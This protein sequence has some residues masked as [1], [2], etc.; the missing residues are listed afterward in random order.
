MRAP[1][2]LLLLG[3]LLAAPAWAAPTLEDAVERLQAGDLRG[4]A[5]LLEG[6]L[7]REPRNAQALF[8]LATARLR[9][10]DVAGGLEALRASVA[11]DPTNLRLRLILGRTY[12]RLRRVEEALAVYREVSRRG[13]EGPEGREARRRARLLEAKVLGE[14]GRLGEALERFEALA[15]EL[16]EDPEVLQGLGL[17]QLLLGRPEQARETF[18]RVASLQ[19]DNASVLRYLG[20]IAY[21]AGDLEEAERRYREVLRLAPPRAPVAQAARLRLAILRGLRA[22]DGG[23]YRA[24]AEAFQEALRLSPRDPVARLNLAAAYRG[25]ERYERAEALLLGLLQDDPDNLDARLRLGALYL[26]TQRSAEAARTLEALLDRAPDSPQAEQAR[27]LLEQ[28]YATPEGAGLRRQR[29]LGRIAALE[30]RLQESPEDAAAWAELARLRAEQGELEA[31]EE[32]YRRALALRPRQGRLLEEAAS[33]AE[34]RGAYA[35]AAERFARALALAETEAEQRRLRNRLRLAQAERLYSAGRLEAA[36]AWLREVLGEEPDNLFAHYLQGLIA[37]R[38]GRP[39]EAVEAY[40]QVLRLFPGHLGAHLNLAA[41][42]EQLGHLEEAMAQYRAVLR[43][44]SP[45]LAAQAAAR[46][47]ELR[48]RVRGFTYGLSFSLGYDDN[49]NL[50]RRNPVGQARS[51]LDGSITYQRKLRGRPLTWGVT[52]SPGYTVFHRDQFDLVDLQASPF[53]ELRRGRSRWSLS[54]SHTETKGLLVARLVSRSSGA[55]LSLDRRLNWPAWLTFL[56]GEDERRAAPTQLQLSLS[57]QV[58]KSASSPLFDARTTAAGLFLGQSLGG[59]LS[60]E[61]TYGY[62][63]NA[64][65][66]PEGSD[67]AYRAHDLGLRLRRGLAAG[68]SGSVGYALSFRRYT[69]PDSVTRFTRRRVNLLQTFSLGLSFFPREGLSL[70]ASYTFQ[71][72]DSNLPTGLIL[73]PE[74]VGVAIGLQSPSLGDYRRQF[75]NVGLS[76]A[77]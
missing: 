42:Y 24:A 52:L 76:L 11:A 54:L 44:G 57:R 3:A 56:A 60:W 14:E 68:V 63:V 46:L 9:L 23:D 50:S 51:D 18:L 59:G 8:F 19:P 2:A 12:E 30:R 7:E 53:L 69:N 61:L 70:F 25:L 29:E 67:F 37:N 32:A 13:G 77:L 31:A 72:N 58:F 66:R 38:R 75:L 71:Q 6:L 40:R 28:L 55:F 47:N 45:D 22:L 36:S 49:S 35:L 21:G 65:S 27:E 1:L 73:S 43:G 39:E 74:D 26:E 4:A 5:A 16:P 33:L 62:T 34:R 48:R 64:N 10:G 17:T 41:T 20:D 15:R